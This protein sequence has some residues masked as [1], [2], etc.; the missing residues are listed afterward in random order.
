E[1]ARDAVYFGILVF[2]SARHRGRTLYPRLAG[3]MAELAADDGGV[4]VFDVCEHNL[5][6]LGVERQLSR[7]TGWFPGG[8]FTRVDTQAFYA[9]EFNREALPDAIAAAEAVVVDLSSQRDA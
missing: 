6:G 9:M 7:I 8:A 4:I 3:K 5:H 1:A 2:V